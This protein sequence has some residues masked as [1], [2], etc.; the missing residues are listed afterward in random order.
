MTA[1]A[2][3]LTADAVRDALYARMAQYSTHARQKTL[4]EAVTETFEL[5]AY[6][7][8]RDPTTGDEDVIGND[9]FTGLRPTQA[10]ALQAIVREAKLEAVQDAEALIVKRVV[11]TALA[12]AAAEPDA[13]LAFVPDEPEPPAAAA[14]AVPSLREAIEAVW[15]RQPSI[16]LSIADRWSDAFT[17]ATGVPAQLWDVAALRGHEDERVRELADEAI[18]PIRLETTERV[19]A[20]LTA[21]AERFAAEHPD[22]PRAKAA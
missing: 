14:L 8:E 18:E 17:E 11:A 7:V 5:I 6:S 4:A 2:R 19:L 16:G 10:R 9:V 12:F 22:A 13:L 21:A 15:R 20:A 1:T 3:S